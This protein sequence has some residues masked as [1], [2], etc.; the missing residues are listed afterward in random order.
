[1]VKSLRDTLAH[2]YPWPGNVRELEQAV[3]R[4]LLNGRYEGVSTGD[5]QEKD[6]RLTG[7][8]RDGSLT[9]TELLSNYCR[10]LY[11]RLG[12]YEQVA[13]HIELDRR[14]VKKYIERG[15]A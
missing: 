8:L 1:V 10:A 14:T 15:A 6:D 2:D 3:R 13:R 4:I 9:A 5:T 11:A 7:L 12:S